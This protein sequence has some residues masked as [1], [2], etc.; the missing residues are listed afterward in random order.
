V[1][2]GQNDEVFFA[3]KFASVFKAAGKDIPVTIL[4]G[5]D[6]IALTL[7]PTAIQAAVNTVEDMDH[8]R[9]N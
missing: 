9:P 8:E 7:N 5:I 1:L 4:P 2:V 3:D 6:H